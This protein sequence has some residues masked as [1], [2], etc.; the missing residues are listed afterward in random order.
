MKAA[1]RVFPLC[2]RMAEDGNPNSLSDA[3]VGALAARASVLGAG[4]NVKINAASL[5]D[6]DKAL[7]LINEA[8]SLME[9][10]NKEE[11]LIMDIMRQLD[12]KE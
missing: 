11:Q 1:M 10:A 2:K 9:S 4:L 12:P 6:R 7:S 3:G 8:N 5:K